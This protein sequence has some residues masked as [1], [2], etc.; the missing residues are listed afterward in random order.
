MKELQ[1]NKSWISILDKEKSDYYKGGDR[2][3]FF[4]YLLKKP[5]SI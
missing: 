5:L 3:P 4:P 2:I 1:N